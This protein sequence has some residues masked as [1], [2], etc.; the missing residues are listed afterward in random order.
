[1]GGTN[2]HV[3]T[4]DSAETL[5]VKWAA[6]EGGTPADNSIT[7]AKLSQVATATIKGRATAATGNV[8]DLTAAQARGVLGLATTDNATFGSLQNT[9]IGSTTRSSGAFTSLSSSQGT[10]TANSPVSIAATWNNG[11]V[12][13][14]ALDIS[15]SNTDSLAASNFITFRAGGSGTTTMAAVVRTGAAFFGQG[16]VS[17]GTG[18]NSVVLYNGGT[19]SFS[20]SGGVT[21]DASTG[22]T[23][24]RREAANTLAMYNT[25]NAQTFRL[26][27]TFSS[28]TSF[29]RLNIAAQTGGSFILG[30]E[31]GSGGGSARGLEL[32]TDNVAR[33]SIGS[34]GQIGFFGATAAAQPAAVADA[35]DAATVIT[36]LNALLSRM[37]TLG[38]IAT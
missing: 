4:V 27:S 36:Q 35:T 13:F 28:S 18:A 37:R 16:T 24:L 8:E 10:I 2:G 33:I 12:A 11:A 25:S 14:T 15:I 31:K 29:E 30:T 32:R 1:V 26:Y 34:A 9:P 38:L 7:N 19:L 6:A 22:D 3:L 20:S 21:A 5:G 17:I 23:I